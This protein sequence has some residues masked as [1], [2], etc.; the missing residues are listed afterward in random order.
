VRLVIRFGGEG[1]AELHPVVLQP[2]QW[3]F[4]DGASSEWETRGGSCGV[5]TQ[6]SYPEVLACSAGA[7]VTGVEVINDSGWMH[8][9]GG[10]FRTRGRNSSGAVRGTR[11]LTVDR[12]NG[13]LTVVREGIVQVHD[14]GTGERV[15]VRAGQ[16]YF[17]RAANR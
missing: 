6:Q 5:R 3:S 8:P 14:Y 16:S 1:L 10:D 12:C 17:A 9:S 4:V 13:T 15:L 2:G 7:E 11:W